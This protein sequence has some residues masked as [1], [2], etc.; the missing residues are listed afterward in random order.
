MTGEEA[1]R[2]AEADFVEF[3]AAR[4]GLAVRSATL[5]CDEPV[6]GERVA[7][8]AF[9]HLARNWSAAREEGPESVLR[10][11]LHRRAVAAVRDPVPDAPPDP[12]ATH[13]GG[14]TPAGVDV[15]TERRAAVRTALTRLTARQRSAAVQHWL[16]DRPEPEVARVLRTDPGVVHE[17]LRAVRAA[18]AAADVRPVPGVDETHPRELLELVAD[19]LDEPPLAEEAW[20]RAVGA[21]RTARRRAVL[22]GGVVVAAGAAATALLGRDEP[23]RRTLRPSATPTPGAGRLTGVQVAG[24]AVYFAPPPDEEEGLPPYPDAAETALPGKLGPG[25]DFVLLSSAGSTASVRAVFLIRVGDDRY[26]PA[27]FMPRQAPAPLLVPMA[28]LHAVSDPAGNRTLPVGPRTIDSER[29]RLVFP[30]PGAVVVLEV[31]SA[32]TFRFPVPDEHLTTAGWASDGRTIVATGSSGSWLVDS[33]TGEATATVIPVN[34]GW[35]DVGATEAGPVVRGYS[36]RGQIVDVRSVDGPRVDVS[37]EAISTTEGWACRLTFFGSVEAMQN[38]VQGL[39]AVQR[40]LRPQPRILAATR[41]AGVQLGAYRP[42]AW[43]P[44]ETVLFESRSNAA[45]GRPVLRLLAWDV[46]EARLYRVASLDTPAYP[47]PGASDD[48]FTGAWAL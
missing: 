31:R 48:P 45:T 7:L 3:A 35:A 41:A 29:H 43:G 24:A 2:S 44:R 37:G 47:V 4:E 20:R 12:P 21:R 39:F 38:R 17:D 33:R 10:V 26:Q 14:A 25:T 18:L 23:A 1:G 16:E 28:A 30:Q 40:G 27:L 19:E 15:L 6:L 34:A 8:E 46:L 13:P 5:V 42:L 32:R 9:T 36:G 11:E 22:V